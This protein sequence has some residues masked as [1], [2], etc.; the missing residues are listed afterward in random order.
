MPE[1]QP[2]ETTQPVQALQASQTPQTV[3]EPPADAKPVQQTIGN[4]VAGQFETETQQMQAASGGP[5]F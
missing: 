5:G 2:I 4:I 3:T 1:P